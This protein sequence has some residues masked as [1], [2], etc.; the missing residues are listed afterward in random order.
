VPHTTGKELTSKT[1][2]QTQWQVPKE[3]HAEGGDKGDSRGSYDIVPPQFVLADVVSGIGSADRVV[4]SASA[5]TWS[6]SVREDG[7]VD[8]DDLSVSYGLAFSPKTYIEHSSSGN[9][10]R[11]YLR[12]ELRPR[13]LQGVSTAFQAEPPPCETSCDSLIDRL[14]GEAHRLPAQ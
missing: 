1:W 14:G 8:T 12:D 4:C 10:T 7:S 2:S 6:T 13:P 9:C 11:P 5:D 3:T